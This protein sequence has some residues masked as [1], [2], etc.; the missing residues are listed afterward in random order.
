MNT[1]RELIDY[2]LDCIEIEDMLSLTFDLSSNGKNF[3]S[4]IFKSEEFFIQKKNI[5]NITKRKNF[6]KIY[7]E[8]FKI[9]EK[10]NHLFYGFPIVIDNDGKIGPL[11]F[12]ELFIL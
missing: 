11:F 6:D 4:G 5:V 2:Y 10:N 8:N 7:E 3:F 1:Y 12:T 9:N